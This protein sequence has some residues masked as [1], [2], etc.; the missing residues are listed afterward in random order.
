MM[1]I[2]H[3]SNISSPKL[4]VF[5]ICECNLFNYLNCVR[6]RVKV[7]D[8]FCYSFN[9]FFNKKYPPG[10]RPGDGP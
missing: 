2:N 6:L 8:N 10:A 1:R 5:V 3:C 7:I 4:L 9:V